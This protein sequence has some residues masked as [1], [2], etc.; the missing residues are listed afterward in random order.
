MHNIDCYGIR[1]GSIPDLEQG[2]EKLADAGISRERKVQRSIRNFVQWRETATNSVGISRRR[3]NI[4]CF[5][6]LNTIDIGKKIRCQWQFAI[7][8][9]AD[10]RELLRNKAVMS[11]RY[12]KRARWALRGLRD[13]ELLFIQNARVVLCARKKS[14][15]QRKA[16]GKYQDEMGDALRVWLLIIAQRNGP[17]SIWLKID[18]G[19]AFNRRHV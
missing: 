11:G 19:V 9:I 1:Y 5:F 12:V 18:L 4:Y 3:Y 15:W 17:T 2:C 6:F 8:T 10:I 16:R 13:C 14:S 7:E